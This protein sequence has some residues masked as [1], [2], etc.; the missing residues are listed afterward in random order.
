MKWHCLVLFISSSY[1]DHSNEIQ[2]VLYIANDAN[3]VPEVMLDS[4]NFTTDY[5][6]INSLY[7]RSKSIER[8]KAHS[9][10]LTFFLANTYLFIFF[11]YT[12]TSP[13]ISNCGSTPEITIIY[14][15]YDISYQSI[16]IFCQN[17]IGSIIFFHIGVSTRQ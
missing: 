16:N 2:I 8:R 10:S 13:L 17:K 5:N 14:L 11:T 3:Q 6:K 15:L 1:S 7:N 9:L 12:V 4:I